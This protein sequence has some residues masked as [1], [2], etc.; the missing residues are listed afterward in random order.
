MLVKWLVFILVVGSLGCCLT[1]IVT[2]VSLAKGRMR[3]LG[4]LLIALAIPLGAIDQAITTS[5]LAPGVMGLLAG[6]FLAGVGVRKYRRDPEG[7]TP[8]AQML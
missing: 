3:F 7:R 8:P 1:A 4:S 6:A 2:P 5:D